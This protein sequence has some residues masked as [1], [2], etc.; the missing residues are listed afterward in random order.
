LPR[1]RPT[2]RKKTR[3]EIDRENKAFFDEGKGP[4]FREPKE[5]RE[6]LMV[7]FGKIQ[8]K[9]ARNAVFPLKS[10]CFAPPGKAGNGD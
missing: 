4:I 10:G 3:G 9:N 5:T 6:T 1:G 2:P 7:S 8:R